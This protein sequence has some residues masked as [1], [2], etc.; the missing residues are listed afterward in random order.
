MRSSRKSGDQTRGSDRRGF[1]LLEL[2][3]SIGIIAILMSLIMPA[4]FSAR[5]SARRITCQ[6]HLRQM[7]L[8]LTNF[9]DVQGRYPAA[10]TFSATGPDGYFSW[11]LPLLPHMDQAPI[12]QKWNRDL[13]H[14]NPANRPLALTRLEG[15]ECPDDIT[16]MPGQSNLSYVVN[17]GFG[18][19]VPDDCIVTL[20]V[21]ETPPQYAVPIDLN[22]NGVTC[23][24][25][26]GTDGAPD[27]RDLF[28]QSGV[29][30]VENY[31]FGSG[32]L[33][34]HRPA[35]IIDGLSHTVFVS[36][37]VRAG[38]DPLFPDITGWASPLAY[39]MS[40][41]LSG[42][43]CDGLSCSTGNVD[44]ANANA[45]G[46]IPARFEAINSARNQA[47]G[48]APWPTSFHDG[49][50]H[51]LFGDGHVKFLSANI[52]GLTYACLVTPQGSHLPGALK[53]PAFVSTAD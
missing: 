48:Q 52:N 19:S 33:R 40:F 17:G 28:W 24:P 12:Y 1:T 50:V 10:G 53:Q 35:T 41:F 6:N 8:A 43:V 51:M 34:H 18:W 47:E 9:A 44:Y 37:N 36:E 39:R 26:P 25:P 7:G 29:F 38:W 15:F 2:L 16:I 27:D 13:A 23:I 46:V 49:G 30:F 5:G 31:P 20:H 45:Q 14:E 11:V 42:Y 3:V 21:N 32:T 4:V 22:G